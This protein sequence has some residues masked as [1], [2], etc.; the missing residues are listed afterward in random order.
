MGFKF[1]TRLSNN[2]DLKTTNLFWNLSRKVMEIY[3]KLPNSWKRRELKKLKVRK[4]AKRERKSGRSTSKKIALPLMRKPKPRMV[5]K[6]ISA[7]K[8]WA[9]QRKEFETGWSK[10]ILISLNS[11]REWRNSGSRV[12]KRIL[13]HSKK[14]KEMNRR[15]KKF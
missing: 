5:R 7:K 11:T 3:L 14:A 15:L 6:P 9:K 10:N 12:R 1:N 4:T 8:K 2:R 13:K